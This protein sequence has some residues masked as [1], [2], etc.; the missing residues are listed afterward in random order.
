[1]AQLLKHIYNRNFFGKFL[2]AFEALHP[3]LDHGYFM[4]HVLSDDWDGLELKERMH[5]VTEVLHDCLSK[6]YEED[7]RL[8][9]KLIPELLNSGF[10]PDMLEFIFLPHY[11]QTYGLDYAETSLQAIEQMTQFI[12]C[13]FAIRPFFLSD[14]EYI[15]ELMRKWSTHTHAGVRRLSSEGSRPRLPWAMGIPYLKKHPEQIIPILENLKDDPSET[16]RRSVANNLNDISKD[17]PNLVI[18]LTGSWFN[19]SLDRKRMLK[20]ACRTLL[21]EGNVQALE[22]FG[23]QNLN[24]VEIP[25]F[26]LHTPQVKTGND[27][28]FSFQLRNDDTK[29]SLIRLEYGIHYLKANGQHYKKVFKISEKDYAAGSTTDI[30]KKHSF[31]VITTRKYYKGIHFLSLILNGQEFYKCSFE[32]I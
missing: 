13:E 15:L 3:D 19:D 26:K 5:R 32:L 2:N 27:L 23:F 10:K 31:R 16:V 1:M 25:F 7:I 30:V 18:E 11:I 9:I 4:N 14:P 8:L 22:I 12:S 17:H 20:H 6:E 29:T 28:E 24:K 21:K